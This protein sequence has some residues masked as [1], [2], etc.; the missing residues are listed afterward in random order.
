MKQLSYHII[1]NKILMHS[2]PEK[3]TRELG[4]MK[5]AKNLHII[6]FHLQNTVEMTKS[7]KRR[8]NWWLWEVEGQEEDVYDSKQAPW[9]SM[10]WW[11]CCLNVNMLT[12]ILVMILQDVNIRGNWKMEKE[13][14]LYDFLQ[15]HVNLQ[16][17]E[18][19]FN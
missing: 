8:T 15:F 13:I 11:K 12:V 14:F 16:L 19:K 6:W 2:K 1:K 9:G 10:W 17:F 5:K 18:N 4:W 3:I 7:L